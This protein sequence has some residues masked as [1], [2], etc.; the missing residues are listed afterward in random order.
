MTALAKPIARE[1]N[2][3]ILMLDAEA[4]VARM[5]AAIKE[6][7]LKDLKRKGVVLGLSGGIDSTVTAALAVKALGKDRVFGIL[8]PERDSDPESE[9]L[10]RLVAGTLGIDCDVE[11]IYPALQGARCY[12]RRD[13]FI[14]T[15]VP[16][17]GPDWKCKI[18]L[19]NENSAMG[20]AISFLVV[21]TPSG[22][23][24]QHRMTA[25]AYRGIIAAANMKQRTRKQIEY[26]HADRLGFAVAGTPNKLEYDQGFFVKQGD[27]AADFKPIAHLYKSQV[28]Q[29]ARHL[30]MPAEICAR[31]P[32]TDTW[33]LPQGQDEFYFSVSY[34]I[35]DLCLHGMESQR[36]A[37]DVARDAGISPEQVRTVWKEIDGKRK[38]TRYL[39]A[40]PILFRQD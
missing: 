1:P 13:D 3:D 34:P 7:V 32:T 25:E 36:S 15:I 22:E 2:T 38:A 37:E 29:L 18:V 24:S 16:E 35:M 21:E 11:D 10:G 14:R 23:R 39:H 31:A 27:G 8:M 20:F 40:A 12:E 17:Y 28:Y 6:T 4:E 19:S 9:R 5:A 30:G 26:Y 33:S